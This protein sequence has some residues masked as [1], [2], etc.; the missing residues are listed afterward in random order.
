M[1]HLPQGGTTSFCLDCSRDELVTHHVSSFVQLLFLASFG[2]PL[3]PLPVPGK[4]RQKANSLSALF[5]GSEDLA[6]VRK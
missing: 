5:E 1:N 3:G 2:P 4:C 6:L